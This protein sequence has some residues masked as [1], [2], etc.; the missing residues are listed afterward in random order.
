MLSVPDKLL[1]KH[2]KY[3]I[4]FFEEVWGTQ[5]GNDLKSYFMAI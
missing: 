3:D 5:E 4:S 2:F 1:L